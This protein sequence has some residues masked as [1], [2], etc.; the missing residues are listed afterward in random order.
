MTLQ[1]SDLN[2]GKR[3]RII[4]LEGSGPTF[5]RMIDMGITPGSLVEV[6]RFAPLGDPIAIKVKGYQLSLRRAEASTVT[7]RLSPYC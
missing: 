4:A 6:Q 3:G 2:P 5:R 1:L 7:S